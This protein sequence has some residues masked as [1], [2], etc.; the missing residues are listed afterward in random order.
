MFSKA[1]IF[2]PLPHGSLSGFEKRINKIAQYIGLGI[3]LSR[4][5]SI[6]IQE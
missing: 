1:M 6:S 4:Y 5:N 2:Q 3:D